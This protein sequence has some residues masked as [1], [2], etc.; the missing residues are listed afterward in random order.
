MIDKIMA[1]VDK[2]IDDMEKDK[3]SPDDILV[4]SF[5]VLNKAHETPGN[6]STPEIEIAGW[7]FITA[8]NAKFHR[9]KIAHKPSID[10][11]KTIIK[12]AKF[13]DILPITILEFFPECENPLFEEYDKKIIDIIERSK[14]NITT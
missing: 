8:Y 9:F 5:N 13:I 11:V 6:I 12:F 4:N 1:E 14:K 10:E 7:N 2:V 3:I